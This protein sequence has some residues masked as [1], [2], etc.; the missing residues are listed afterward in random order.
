MSEEATIRRGVRNARYTTVPN[1]VFE[2]SRLSMEARWLLGYLLSKPDGWIVRLGDIRKKGGCGRDKAR[3]M[4]SEL[5]DAGYAEKEAAR[6]DGKFNGLAVVI[7][8]E[9]ITAPQT[10]VDESVA[11]VPQ[12]EKPAT[13]LP[14]PANPPLVNTDN[15][16]I[17]ENRI[18]REGASARDR[19]KAVEKWLKRHHPSWPSFIS[20]SA[21]AALKAA[22][23][24]SEDERA[25]AAD[26]MADYLAAEK[27]HGRC[28][29]STYLTEKRWERLPP[30]SAETQ[31][32]EAAPFG[33]LSMCLRF[34]RLLAGAGPIPAPTGFVATLIAQG[35]ERAEREISERR[36]RYGYPAVN[37]M[38]ELAA[39]GRGHVVRPD[40]LRLERFASG[41]EKVR[42]GSE[43]WLAWEHLHA[44][45]DWPWLPDPGKQDWV[46]FP[47]GGPDRFSEFEQA[48]RGDDD[49]GQP[50]AAE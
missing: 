35:G 43:L 38:D 3:S 29:F 5:V 49:A 11:F 30:K 15:I 20:D 42:V 32:V 17:T 16:A 14:A 46:Y 24:L 31:I 28:A 41:F 10:V 34:A 39:V 7:Y 9:P 40:D 6:K 48:M 47:A 23:D 18:E 26:R 45:R 8:D 33:K 13:V 36:K 22:L 21:S 4:V 2:D 44:E 37:R 1:H 27:G 12:P 50:Q 25:A 19:E